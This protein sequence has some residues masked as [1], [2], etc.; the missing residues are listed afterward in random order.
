MRAA[1]FNVEVALNIDFGRKNTF[2]GPNS[3][4]ARIEPGARCTLSVSFAPTKTGTRIATLSITDDGGGS[5]QT[6]PLIRH[7][8][9]T[10]QRQVLPKS[11]PEPN[12]PTSTRR[13]PQYPNKNPAAYD[14]VDL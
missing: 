11:S 7:G 6:V 5:P 9:L 14:G 10:L 12:S 3:C 1:A 8:R 4:G 2:P 13:V